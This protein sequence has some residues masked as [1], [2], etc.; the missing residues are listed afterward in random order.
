MPMIKQT[1]VFK[2][3]TS[4]S[5]RYNQLVIVFQDSGDEISRPIED[6]AVIIVENQQVRI[7]VPLLNALTENNVAV[8]FCDERSMPKSMLMNL[9]GNSTLQECYRY[10]LS[11]SLPLKK[12]IWK[13]LVEGKIRN[14]SYLL[15]KLGK[16]GS[17]LKPYY[18][19]V[20]S[21]DSDNKEGAAARIYWRSLFGEDFV[22]DRYGGPPNEFLNYG[23]SILRAA[24]T[25]AI[26]GS[27]LYPAFAVFHKSRY[28]AFPLSDDTMEPY[29][30]FVD[31]VVHHLYID[32]GYRDLSTE[33]KMKLQ[34]VLF[35]DV[36]MGQYTRPLEIALSM[37]TSSLDKF[38]RGETDKL[39]LP[40]LE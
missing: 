37:T 28:N 9:D 24:V 40:I 26:V 30:P 19:N 20:K 18:Q 32:E 38:F 33:V 14:Q 21:G 2:R 29:R 13:Q 5:L 31:E 17:V 36:S 23:Y 35:C 10:Q 3:P 34:R 11:A 39:N 12:N 8:V 22:R 15:S 16:D 25:R 4:L 7:T 1:L 27:G 6:I